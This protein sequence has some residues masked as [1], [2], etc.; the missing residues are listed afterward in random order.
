MPT[1]SS[2]CIVRAAVLT[3]VLLAGGAAISNG[4]ASGLKIEN[5]HAIVLDPACHAC[6]GANAD[7]RLKALTASTLALDYGEVV[8]KPPGKNFGARVQLRVFDATGQT[9]TTRNS[10][11]VNELAT[12]RITIVG[13]LEE[14]DWEIPVLNGGILVDKITVRNPHVNLDVK[15]DVPDSSYPELVFV[16]EG[17]SFLAFKNDDNVPYSVS[18]TYWGMPTTLC[19]GAHQMNGAACDPAA[20]ANSRALICDLKLPAHSTRD[21]AISAPAEWFGLSSF[22]SF[23]TKASY[24][25][26]IASF[27]RDLAG[28]VGVRIKVALKDETLDSRIRIQLCS[29]E[30]GYDSAAPAR[31]FRV[32][33]HLTALRKG[34]QAFWGYLIVFL[35]LFAGGVTSLV[36]NFALPM[37]ERRLRVKQRLAEADRKVGDVSVDFDSRVRVPLGVERRRLSIRLRTLR[38]YN[39]QFSQEMIEIEQGIDRLTKRLDIVERMQ[40]SLRLYWALRQRDIPVRLIDQIEAARKRVVD[41]LQKTDPGDADLQEALGA[42]QDIDRTVAGASQPNI[43]LA[44]RLIEE[45]KARRDELAKN[46]PEGPL[47][48]AW[49]PEFASLITLLKADLAAAPPDLD[50][51]HPDDYAAMDRLDFKLGLLS[52]YQRVQAGAPS[53]KS[54]SVKMASDRLARE[55]Q[56]ETWDSLSRARCLVRELQEDI[57]PQDVVDEVAKKQVEIKT[58]RVLVRQ[59]ELVQ[60]RLNFHN[61]AVQSASAR[62]E[63]TYRWDFDHDKLAENGWTVSHYFPY[64]T[65]PRWSTHVRESLSKLAGWVRAKL[66]LSQ[67]L[68]SQRG[69]YE[70]LHRA[71]YRVTARLIQNWDGIEVP[72]QVEMTPPLDVYM[73]ARIGSLPVLTEAVRLLL[74]LGLAVLG[75]IAGA[76]EQLL[77]LDVFPALV[78]IFLIGFGADQIKN[79]LTQRSQT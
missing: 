57:F 30:C 79:L 19:G 31:V 41:V 56:N 8:S 10:L 34:S 33:T 48:A 15:L 18:W 72:H 59:F 4:A 40:K 62:I 12:L 35:T 20:S 46:P 5:N 51:V 70:D 63:F 29:T 11:A 44:K 65:E 54:A 37:H 60:L 49:P 68:L 76:K 9:E 74:A 2:S 27:I 73:P 25:N 45:L 75:L 1:N 3:S 26:G 23:N 39:T 78:A 22:P 69:E 58:D 42:L 6:R 61:S 64:D 21:V 53:A 13:T 36:L 43:D 14:G 17:P 47:V 28:W 38:W 7:F 71:P 67:L 32:K 16:R 77:K 50:S 55:L 52:E 66:T 24:I